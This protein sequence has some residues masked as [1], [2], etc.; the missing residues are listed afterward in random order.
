MKS[1]D[2]P[3]QVE[4]LIEKLRWLRLPGMAAAVKD[5]LECAA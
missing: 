2:D 5:L 4:V 1:Q 3:S